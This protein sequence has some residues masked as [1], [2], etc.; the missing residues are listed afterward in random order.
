[1]FQIKGSASRLYFRNYNKVPSLVASAEKLL[2]SMVRLRREKF[3]CDINFQLDGYS[4]F[5]ASYLERYVK[6]K[7]LSHLLQ[8]NGSKTS[9][10]R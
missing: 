3:K 4:K 7:V 2:I 9:E 6:H 10:G 8:S 5:S 1:M